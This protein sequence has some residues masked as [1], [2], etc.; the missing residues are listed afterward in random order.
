MRV[1]NPAPQSEGVIM[2]T[3]VDIQDELLAQAQRHARRTGRPLGALVE[4][5]LRQVL[6]IDPSNAGVGYRLPDCSVG[7]SGRPDP[8]VHYSWPKIR[9]MIY[10]EPPPH[11]TP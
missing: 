3:T 10:G 2:Q 4:D 6:A 9:G 1:K 5:G 11:C 7:D 8:T